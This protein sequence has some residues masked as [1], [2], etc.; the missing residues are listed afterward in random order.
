MGGCGQPHRRHSSFSSSKY[1]IYLRPFIIFTTLRLYFVCSSLNAFEASK[2]WTGFK[3]HNTH[4]AS[5]VAPGNNTQH[6]RFPCSRFDELL[7]ATIPVTDTAFYTA[8]VNVVFSIAQQMIAQRW[9]IQFI[10]VASLDS[11][12]ASMGPV[13]V[14]LLLFCMLTVNFP[15]AYKVFQEDSNNSPHQRVELHQDIPSTVVHWASMSSAVTSHEAPTETGVG[16]VVLLPDLARRRPIAG[17][18]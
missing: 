16:P 18:S 4:S 14:S 12:T 13:F 5:Q 10:L 11:L 3:K 17:R 2:R 15:T 7:I 9:K 6:R 1:T 8:T